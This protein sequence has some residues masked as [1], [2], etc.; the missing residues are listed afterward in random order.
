MNWI[1]SRWIRLILIKL[2][3]LVAFGFTS[4]LGI[5]PIEGKYTSAICSILIF[6]SIIVSPDFSPISYIMNNKRKNFILLGILIVAAMPASYLSSP[7]ER[8]LTW[9]LIFSSAG[10]FLGILMSR[11]VDFVSGSGR[12]RPKSK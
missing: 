4:P 3:M 5:L 7:L 6:F 11:V 8:R 2:P 1:D 9:I 10:L 12:R